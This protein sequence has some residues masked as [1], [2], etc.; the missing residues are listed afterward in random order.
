M[1]IDAREWADRRLA[2]GSDVEATQV[3]I[4][5]IRAVIADEREAAKPEPVAEAGVPEWLDSLRKEL[6]LAHA[7][8]GTWDAV[9]KAA[10]SEIAR[11]V[12][13]AVAEKDKR[14]AE[15]QTNLAYLLMRV[16]GAVRVCE[17]GGPEDVNKS[18]AVSVIKLIE[19]LDA[20]QA[21][22]ERLRNDVGDDI[23]TL[24]AENTKLRAEN[25]RL[26]RPVDG[27]DWKSL[28][29]TET[30]R[31][32][33][34]SEWLRE[35]IEPLLQAE[36][37]ARESAEAERNELRELV[38]TRRVFVYFEGPKAEVLRRPIMDSELDAVLAAYR[39]E[40]AKVRT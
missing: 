22:V 40:K 19:Q 35:V 33:Y 20:S 30:P 37:N 17:G 27:V 26:T 39:A 28:W 12:A 36:R 21:E 8:F 10:E 1:S 14:I 6:R 16:P 5:L 3:H 25:A 9:A 29:D 15:F 31:A 7:T 13:E 34:A 32:R 38:Q 2:A 23:A 11:R 18:I 24:K 4:D